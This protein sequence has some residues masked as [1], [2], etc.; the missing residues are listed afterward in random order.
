MVAPSTGYHPIRMIQ[1]HATITSHTPSLQRS[2]SMNNFNKNFP[3]GKLF[4]QTHSIMSQG[5][6]AQE[7]KNSLNPK[8]IKFSLNG[9]VEDGDELSTTESP[10]TS[11]SSVRSHDIVVN[12][13]VENAAPLYNNNLNKN[14]D[15]YVQNENSEFDNLID[16][17]NDEGSLSVDNDDQHLYDEAD[18][19]NFVESLNSSIEKNLNIKYRKH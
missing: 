1:H 8:K 4:K 11:N 14:N 17:I 18:Q 7:K 19:A 12:K 3:A 5:K 16:P 9:K 10:K 6:N 2:K 15:K 13:E